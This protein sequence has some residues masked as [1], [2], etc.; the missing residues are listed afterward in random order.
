MSHE[1]PTLYGTEKNGKVKTWVATIKTVD[2]SSSGGN[3]I[4]ISTITYGQLD[5]KKQII[6]REYTTGKNIGKSNET[7]P[8]QQCFLETERK[9]K[10]KQKENYKVENEEKDEIILPML[11]MT[12][13]IDSKKKKNIEFPC[14]IQP[15]LDGLRCILYKKDGKVIGQSRTGTI[16]ESISFLT[17]SLSTFFQKNNVI[18]DG[19]LYTMDIPF[20]TLAGLLKK[21]KISE[22]DQ[23]Q[24]KH[25]KYHIYDMISD[26]PFNERFQTLQQFKLSPYCELVKTEEIQNTD[27]FKQIFSSYI[28]QGFEGVMLRNVFG[29]YQQGYRSHDLQKYKEFH[30]DE[31]EITGFEDGEGRDKGCVIW[32]C[33]K[34]KEF[35]VRPRGTM[36]QRKEW[37]KNGKK[38][39][40]KM[41][42]VIYQELS[43]QN[44]PRFPVGKAIRE[45]Y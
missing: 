27:Q 32:I 12:F 8:F 22:Q 34:D 10:D 40:G 6:T 41:L 11:A 7:S 29:L 3:K 13:S 31:Y 21:K 9:W 33:K 19:E 43:E 42:T 14:M 23:E 36:E 45:D 39:I 2:L 44:V 5:G 28:E 20:E 17:E 15:K 30:E 16:F 25:I 24:L 18:L 4:V 38:Y 1:F 26:Q 35:R 37:F